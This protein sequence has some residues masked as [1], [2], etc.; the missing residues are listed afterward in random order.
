MQPNRTDKHCPLCEAPGT[1]VFF[2]LSDVPTYVNFLWPTRDEALACTR[3]TIRLAACDRCGLIYNAAYDPRRLQYRPGYENSLHYSAVFQTY[4]RA[5]ARQLVERFDLRGKRI[6]D[7]G[8]GRGDFL[9]M[10]CD[11]GDNRGV[12]FDPSHTEPPEDVVQPDRVTFVRDFYSERYASDPF[13]FVCSRHTLEHVERPQDLLAPLRRGIGDRSSTPVFFEVPN[14]RY[15]IDNVFV[16][17]I[18]YEHPLYFVDV[19]LERTFLTHGFKP[20]RTY[21]T[22]DGQYLCIE[23]RPHGGES[24]STGDDPRLGDLKRSL[25]QFE[26]R[27]ASYRDEWQQRL[28][29]HANSG[30]RVALWGA[31]SK[32]VMFLNTF[33]PQPHIGSVIDINPRKH[34]MHIAGTGQRIEGPI[35]LKS[36]PA[37]VIIIANPVYR[38]EIKR[39]CAEMG[40]HP[41]LELL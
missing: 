27:Y 1:R 23:A 37:D 16:W 2:E 6:A 28:D 5:L 31:G 20:E 13:D 10:L 39:T 35:H 21:D 11:A 34:G 33:S 17:D 4:A 15:T 41:D 14:A 22:F 18:I 30:K 40:I 7:I 38:D 24:A 29:D 8:C 25:E 12:G 26:D 36:A 32:G 9:Y 3:G 19:S